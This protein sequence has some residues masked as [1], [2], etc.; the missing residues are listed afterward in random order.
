MEKKTYLK[1]TDIKAYQSA[2]ALSN[3]VWEIVIKWKIF[4]KDTLGKQLVRAI[5]SISANIAEGFGRH[6]KNDKIRFYIIARGSLLECMDW[7]EKAKIRNLLDN[8]QYE[9]MTTTLKGL[10]K[11]INALI[12]QTKEN[13]SE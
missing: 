10:P 7:V 6:H 8:Q 5:D 13:L 2:F 9:K 11:L 12:K 3:E 1:V 4:E